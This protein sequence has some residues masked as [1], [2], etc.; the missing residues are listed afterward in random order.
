M[1]TRAVEMIGRHDQVETL[2]RLLDAARSGTGAT[3]FVVG[4]SGI[5][6]SRLVAEAGRLA[7]ASGMVLS[8]GRGSSIGPI[9]P[10][11]SLTEALLS[12]TRA[13]PPIAVDELGAYRPILG[14]LLPGWG[15]AAAKPE[16]SSVVVLAEG[17]LRLISLAGRQR[18]CLM[19]LDD[20]QY[21]DAETL[22]VLEYLVDNLDGQP[23]A[24][25]ATIRAE[26]CPALDLA[27]SAA[28][29][30]AALLHELDRLGEPELRELIGACLGAAA[31][32]VPEQVA[33]H[34]WHNSAGN[35][36]L[37]EELLGEMVDT[38]LLV[39]GPDGWR[40][41]GPPQTSIPASLARRLAQRL[42][43]SEPRQRELLLAAAAF[44][45]RFPLTVLQVMTGLDDRGLLRHLHDGLAAELVRVDEHNPE[46]YAFR[47]PLTSGALLSGCAPAVRVAL[48]TR[49][50][51]A[52]QAVHPTLPGAWCQLA[53]TLRLDAGDRVGAGRHFAEAGRRALANG[54]ADSA[55]RLLEEARSLL[56][57]EDAEYPDVLESL[58]HALAEAGLIDRSLSMMSTLDGLGG[59]LGRR[60]R[61]A[62]H[63]RL[64][65]AAN[66][67]ARPA[68]GMAQIE[69]ARRLLGP[70][71]T[72][73]E[74]ASIDVVAAHLVLDLPGRQ[75]IELAEEMARRAATVAERV[76][77]PVVAC[78]AWQLLGALVRG[79]DLDEATAC[80][81][82]ARALAVRHEL[83][84]W[85]IHALVR[86]GN[87]DAVRDAGLHRLQRAREVA[88]TAGAVT[89]GYQ[90]EASI[91]LQLVL[92]GDYPQAE[93]IVDKCL[94]ATT[95]LHLM[96][97]ARHLLQTRA[98]AAGHRGRRREMDNAL[99][100]LKRHQGAAPSRDHKVYGLART[101]CALLEENRPRAL[102]ELASVLQGERDN[103][104]L[105]PLTGR[106]G[107]HVLLQA[108]AGD[109]DQAAYDEA[110]TAPASTMRWNRQ[111]V[112]FAG[113]VLAGR[114]G[115]GEQADASVAA[116]LSAAQ[117]YPMTRHLGLRLIGE[118][119]LAQ[120]WGDPVTWL[121]EAEGYFHEA[122]VPAVAGACRALLR[123]AGVLIGQRREGADDIPADL[124]S[125]G[126]T[127][128]E[129]E[130]LRMLVDRLG[131]REIADRLH[132]SPRT[133]EKYV[134]QL[135]TKTGRTGRHGLSELALS[136]ARQ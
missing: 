81:E 45:Q 85:E 60:R 64:A 89:A 72:D 16:E 68:D 124:R 8:R 130:V 102:D 119:A 110:R 14:R 97:T 74:T 115:R 53:A 33:A 48:A 78:Q 35:P 73:A 36:S 66:L 105:S 56:A 76:P 67:A 96:E 118:T 10:F 57:G 134:A 125:A 90:A 44:G 6:R 75:Q 83:P 7:A 94:E 22:A 18:G 3:M 34:I 62:L 127:V 131:N 126:V 13:V 21:A 38:G 17:V 20:L 65:W 43:H 106:H 63:T 25:L 1:R 26:D 2:H 11:R 100:D 123:R 135:I 71:A 101:F 4:E 50:A 122:G 79:R 23:V 87:D 113:A 121:R 111:F 37:A 29:R 133:V 92:C 82:R 47:Q 15:D 39:D 12:L 9:V 88:T 40:M 112:E 55:V 32:D 42:D 19:V 51:D 52:V 86:L 132:L 109:L 104:T 30:G 27:R 59:G 49:A 128:R 80:L 103:P 99:A 98:V 107:L 54:A 58:V 70:D 41:T 24:V 129:Y 93:A 28:Q 31:A 108:L 114:D 91:A 116:A 84:L 5:G 120:G 136:I 69:A 95:R 117:V 77:L 46:W 61:A